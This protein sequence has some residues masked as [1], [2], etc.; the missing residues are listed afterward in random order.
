[1][2]SEP[3]ALTDDERRAYESNVLKSYAYQ[4]V[5]NLQLW[6]PIWVIY[7]QQE[8][9]LSLTQITALDA[10]FFLAQILA[11]I[12]TGAFADRFGRRLSL[13]IGSVTF[14]AAIFVFGIAGNFVVIL[15]SYLVWAVAMAFQSGADSAILFDSLRLLGRAEDYAKI[16]GRSLALMPCAVIIGGLIGAPLAEATDLSTPIIISALIAVVASVIALSFKE[17]P[18][19]SS[20]LSV[21]ATMSGA[22][23]YSF[24]RAT[25]RYSLIY[26][27]LLGVVCY[28]PIIFLQPFATGHG[29]SVA[30]LGYLQAPMRIVGA[31]GFLL[32]YRFLISFGQWR[33]LTLLPLLSFVAYGGLALWDSLYAISLFPVIALVGSLRQLSTVDYVNQRIPSDRRATILSLRQLL[34]ALVLVAAEP[35]MGT[36][37]DSASL[38]VVFMAA[39]LF[40]LLAVGPLI[41]AWR[42][43]EALEDMKA[44][45]T[46]EPA[47]ATS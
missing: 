10:P 41:A 39:A 11:Q 36:L 40:S 35:A 17:P 19:Q 25:I 30:S 5:I 21:M 20:K 4:F 1:M 47:L 7:L 45:E 24:K 26:A 8:R 42:R 23:G 16:Q 18:L 12:P 34:L 6:W 3:P 27:T 46:V 43:A 37:A 29:A 38:R 2:S 14:G 44:S 33:T 32:A 13:F 28:A 31:L 9:G 15:V 22:I